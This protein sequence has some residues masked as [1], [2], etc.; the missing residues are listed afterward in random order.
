MSGKAFSDMRP[1]IV[2]SFFVLAIQRAFAEHRLYPWTEDR[3][4][5]KLYVQTSMAE[6]AKESGIHPA[7]IIDS[8]N[9]SF[10]NDSLGNRASVE[11][12]KMYLVKENLTYTVSGSI[13]FICRCES[14]IS[15]EN[16]AY[17][18][19]SFLTIAKNSVGKVL[20][21]QLLSMP[22]QSKAMPVS[23]SGGSTLYEAQV[24]VSYSYAVNLEVTPVDLG[25]VLDDV[26]SQLSPNSPIIGDG[27][28]GG[29]FTGGQTGNWGGTGEPGGGDAIDDGDVAM[30]FS[31]KK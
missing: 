5:S 25:P 28:V 8:G 3:S 29:T 31:A 11:V 15:A 12:H 4:I 24:Q 23:A 26:L 1:Q 13:A 27:G 20:Q 30:A 21:L 18:L 6:N 9:L 22:Q 7:I 14:K 19:S 10:N 17:E 16:L 2:Q